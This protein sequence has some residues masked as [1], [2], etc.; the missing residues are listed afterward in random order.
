M[1]V[2][3]A[4]VALFFAVLVFAI[5]AAGELLALATYWITFNE[6]FSSD[7]LQTERLAVM[8][9]AK[10]SPGGRSVVGSPWLIHPYYG[11]V[12]NPSGR[13]RIDKF[14][15]YGHEN[16]IQAAGPDKVVI[17]IIGGSVAARLASPAFD[18]AVFESELQ[19]IPPFRNKHVVVVNLG[20]D[21]FKQPQGLMAVND[22]LSRGGHI[23]ILIALDG[24]NEIALPEA[25]GNLADGVSPFYPQHWRHL[26]ETEPD[27]DQMVM[28]AKLH[29]V[30]DLRV[31][32]AAN[33]ARPIVRHLVLPNLIWRVADDHL[34]GTAMRYR[35]A[36]DQQASANPA[37]RVT[38]DQRAFLGPAIEYST[39]RDLY[40][41]IARQWGRSSALLNDIIAARGGRYF[42]FLQP[43]QYVPGSKPMGNEERKRALH[44]ASPYRRS[45]EVGYPYM[46]AMGTSLRRAG[47][48][49]EDLTGLFANNDRELYSDG[50]CH[51]NSEGDAILART[52]AAAIAAR[53]AAGEDVRSLARDV[54]DFGDALFA[55]EELRRFISNPADYNDGSADPIGAATNIT[56]KQRH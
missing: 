47:L 23:D 18:G 33:F 7:R 15:F 53:L 10:E 42:H 40:T 52:I 51:L 34:Q 8:R 31:T 20:N 22:I 56:S 30:S 1:K 14:G 17:A 36:I 9:S 50:C 25:H 46:R 16:Q 4:K 44:S 26:V 13:Q 48:W 43:N 3:S 29:Y 27:P 39:R 41:D 32:L 6:G 49:F 45:V 2:P 35:I 5:F 38:N 12:S 54:V 19:K 55:L 37:S 28:R 21:A 24:F 11:Y